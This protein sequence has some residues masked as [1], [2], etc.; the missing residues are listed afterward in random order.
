MFSGTDQLTIINAIIFRAPSTHYIP[1]I[2]FIYCVIFHIL[3]FPTS[4]LIL[5]VLKDIKTF[6]EINIIFI[7]SFDSDNTK[8][9][10]SM[11]LSFNFVYLL[12]CSTHPDSLG[13]PSL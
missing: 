1:P 8:F 3:F 11:C 12:V 13:K 2:V 5:T 7:V 9:P 10:T 4:S 6:I